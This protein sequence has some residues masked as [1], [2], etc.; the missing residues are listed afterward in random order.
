MSPMRLLIPLL[1]LFSGP[2]LAT[3][4]T[5]A[6]AL[7]SDGRVS[8]AMERLRLHLNDHPEDV[9]AYELLIDI[10]LSAGLSE[11]A[12]SLCRDRIASA[13]DDPDLW[14]LLGR[15][16]VDPE[17]SRS[18][19][20]EALN[21]QPGHARALMGRAAVLRAAG[22]LDDAA[23]AYQQALRHDPTLTEAWIGLWSIQDQ[24]GHPDT[25]L[26]TARQASEAVPT[27]P[28]PWLAIASLDPT[29]AVQTLQQGTQ[30]SP[31]SPRLWSSLA[32][33]A[34][35]ERELVVARQAYAQA[36]ALQPEDKAL[37]IEAAL[38]EEVAA[39]SLDWESALQLL[40]AS[41]APRDPATLMRLDRIVSS[42]PHSGLARMIRGNTRQL[43]G[44]TAEA[45]EDLRAAWQMMPNNPDAAA[46]LGLQ[47]LAQRRPADAIPLLDAAAYARPEDAA[48]G[49]AAAVAHI[50]SGDPRTGGLK[51]VELQ[52][53][54]P[55]HAGPPMAL[56]QL[57][58]GLGEPDQ[59]Y[60]IL[61]EA[62]QR[63]PDPNL[64]AGLAAAAQS[65]GRPAE[66]AT[67]LELL[68]AQTGDPRFAKASRQLFSSDQE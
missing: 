26:I 53:R 43:Q 9:A 29:S 66:A 48:L 20:E 25:A 23:E 18:A 16:L 45:E 1:F 6:E 58:I 67:A 49:I 36:T 63:N 5:D 60:A 68:T 30:A 61:L 14:Y 15:A 32:R 7:L 22:E 64:I 11:E 39:T 17:S 35:R 47:L 52:E 57:L 31:S 2:A 40:D 42:W 34:L 3:G 38:L 13:A 4:L 46:A 56:A 37:R 28:E 33:T 12:E 10:L 24:Q 41:T 21:L 62:I 8:T 59:A 54:H 27:A 51:L 65:A 50:D 19:Y 55:Y 44:L